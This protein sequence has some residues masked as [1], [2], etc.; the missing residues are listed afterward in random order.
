LNIDLKLDNFIHVY[1]RFQ[2]L[3]FSNLEI[4]VSALYLIAAP[5]TLEPVVQEVIERAEKG[6]PMTRTKS[7][8][9]KAY[10]PLSRATA[11]RRWLVTR[12][13]KSPIERSHGIEHFS[14]PPYRN[15]S[16]RWMPAG[17]VWCS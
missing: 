17:V 1:E 11:F 5:S 6:E 3:N 12:R 2:L 16:F 4:G 13:G 9:K 15:L 14:P 10:S 8:R 7:G